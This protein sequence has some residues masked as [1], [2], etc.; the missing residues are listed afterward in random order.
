MNC[1]EVRRSL[2]AYLDGELDLIRQQ[3]RGSRGMSPSV[4]ELPVNILASFPELIHALAQTPSEVRQLFRSEQD[5]H[6]EED[7]K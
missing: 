5:E 7:D 6:N 4:V 3:S 2:D 1:D